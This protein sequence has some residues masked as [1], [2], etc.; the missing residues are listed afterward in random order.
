[1]FQVEFDK[2]KSDLDKFAA[3][4]KQTANEIIANVTTAMEQI[5]RIKNNMQITIKEERSKVGFSGVNF[6]T[7]NVHVTCL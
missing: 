7:K 5:I 2:W 4:V 1:M 3:E 6:Y